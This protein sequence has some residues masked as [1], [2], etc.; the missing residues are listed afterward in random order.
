MKEAKSGK[1]QQIAM[2]NEGQ[3]L[4]DAGDYL[5]ATDLFQSCIDFGYDEDLVTRA[6]ERMYESDLVD[7]KLWFVEEECDDAIESGDEDRISKARMSLIEYFASSKQFFLEEEKRSLAGLQATQNPVYSNLV[8]QAQ[9]R[10][11]EAKGILAAKN[12]DFYEALTN[13]QRAVVYDPENT[14]ARE[15]LSAEYAEIGE[16]LASLVHA[17]KVALQRYES[18]NE[19][20][21]LAVRVPDLE[22][23]LVTP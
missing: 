11:C 18:R 12:G 5:S 16:H 21:S 8:D 7:G 17:K 22:T 10:L 13:Y 3:A 14:E 23:D 9:S 4:M 20:S 19:D 15:R 2:F 1:S 6:T